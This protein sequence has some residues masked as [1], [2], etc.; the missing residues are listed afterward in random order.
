MIKFC[1]IRLALLTYFILYFYFSCIV[2]LDFFIFESFHWQTYMIYFPIPKTAGIITLHRP[3]PVSGMFKSY[4]ST[5]SSLTFCQESVCRNLIV[6]L[7][8]IHQSVAFLLHFSA[9]QLKLNIQLHH[10]SIARL[11]MSLFL[12]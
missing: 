7:S 5:D 11:R 3:F 10:Y 6:S 2:I 12:Y 8:Y 9:I 1:A 4:S